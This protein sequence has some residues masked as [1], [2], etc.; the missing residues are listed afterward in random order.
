MFGQTQNI[1]QFAPSEKDRE[2]GKKYG[3]FMFKNIDY[4]QKIGE[5]TFGNVYK[6]LYTDDQGVKHQIAIKKFKTQ[7]KEGQ[8]DPTFNG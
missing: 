6:A 3:K 2:R 4:V 7:F 8:D 1:N 5:G